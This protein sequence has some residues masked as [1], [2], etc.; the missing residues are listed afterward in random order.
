[1]TSREIPTSLEGRGKAGKAKTDD[2]VSVGG[3]ELGQEMLDV[4]TREYG[5]SIT[6]LLAWRCSERCCGYSS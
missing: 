3:D 1:M 6:T 4:D 2:T 5:S